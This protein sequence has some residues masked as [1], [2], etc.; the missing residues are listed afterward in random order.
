LF[1]ALCCGLTPD[2]FGNV[3]NTAKFNAYFGLNMSG[4]HFL[5]SAPRVC[6]VDDYEQ[7]RPHIQIN[8][9]TT[10]VTQQSKKKIIKKNIETPYY[11]ERINTSGDYR[12]PPLNSF[13]GQGLCDPEYA[14]K[15]AI[16]LGYLKEDNTGYLPSEYIIRAPWVKGLV[17]TFDW[18]AYCRKYGVTTL[19]DIFGDNHKIE[20]IDLLISKS[21]FK[22]WKIYAKK[23]GWQ[24][25]IKSME[26]YNLLWGVVMPNKEHD[27]NM[28][29]L[30]YQYINALILDDND[31]DSLCK[32]TKN[33]LKKL[34]N[35]D[36]DK[37][38]K[39]LIDSPADINENCDDEDIEDVPEKQYKSFLQKAVTHNIDLLQDEHIQ[40]LVL[41][42]CKSKF[43]SA[44][45]GK[46]LCRGN[47]Q[48]LVSDPVAQIQAVIKTHAQDGDIDNIEVKGLIEAN[49]V[50]SN[51]WN[52]QH[53]RKDT[54]KSIVLMRSP[55]IDQ[56]EVA[57]RELIDSEDTKEWY[58]YIKSG[59]VLSIW[60]LT[61]LQ[62][63]N[64][65]FDGDRV[66]SSNN[67]ILKKGA[68][69]NPLPLLYPTP[70]TQS[71]GKITP[72]NLIAADARGL[73][74]KVGSISNKSSSFYA[75]LPLYDE[76]SEEYIELLNRIKILGEL[77]GVEIDKIKT[78]IPPSMPSNWKF[79][80]FPKKVIDKNSKTQTICILSDEEKQEIINHN[81]LVP[82]DKPYFFR[83]IYS[84]LDKE[85]NSYRTGFNKESMYSY[86]KKIE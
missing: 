20:D 6:V 82:D 31:I 54:D 49:A 68:Y 83:Y 57:V 27:D 12:F 29:A 7:I 73:N 48:F 8:Y 11:D 62:C 30:N 85:I 25:H 23:G 61:T 17:I 75:K 21:Q 1:E 22:M 66:Y 77:V 19:K 84:Y 43:K 34:C 65:D 4:V 5:K 74:S 60:D 26:K 86:L 24:Y 28:K 47:F 36:V 53:F 58:K 45:I 56:S 79:K 35:G 71:T 3:F 55:L 81:E 37:I 33:L 38:Y 67:P 10:T 80:P 76:N 15:V 32:T 41:K 59:V 78:G 16:E 39:A 46:L 50:Y 69:K 40:Q 14:K 13:D 70:D 64:C 52:K 51:Y 9:I 72:E 42:E 63:Q 44:K 2:D 18:K